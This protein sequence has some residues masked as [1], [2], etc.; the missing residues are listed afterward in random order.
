MSGAE[1]V[2]VPV[3]FSVVVLAGCSGNVL[4]LLVLARAPRTS[5]SLLVANLASADLVFLVCCVPFHA[6]IYSRQSWPFGEAL[7]KLVHLAQ[8]ASMAASAFSMLA[9]AVDRYCGLVHVLPSRHRHSPRVAVLGSVVCWLA[10]VLL[11]LPAPVVYTVVRYEQLAPQPISLCA[12][13]WPPGT[14]RAA[15]YLAITLLAYV[16]PL[17]T[18]LI[19][20]VPI[21][22]QL[23]QPAPRPASTAARRRG[24]RLIIAVVLVFGLCWLPSHIVWTWTN[25]WPHTWHRTYTFYYARIAAH[26]LAY[27]N[28]AMNPVIYAFMSA[29]FRRAMRRSVPCCSSPTLTDR[30]PIRL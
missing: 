14:S 4:V 27:A 17:F 30:R 8:H 2:V 21:L 9:M 3:I 12:D 13:A 18:I 26:V 28:S 15:Y 11:A 5:A 6:V 22:R 1:T 24:A 19:L 25:L 20:S 29:T 10:A 23:R 7:C 16:L